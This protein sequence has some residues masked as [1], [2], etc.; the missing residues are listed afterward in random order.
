MDWK[1]EYDDCYR[2]TE[3]YNSEDEK[4]N[5]YKMLKDI[6]KYRAS[7]PDAT[8]ASLAMKVDRKILFQEVL[9]VDEDE[10]NI[11]TDVNKKLKLDT[12]K[13]AHLI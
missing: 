1:T 5:C 13:D 11:F 10:S 8:E 6:D 3:L 7:Y 12:A 2:I 4:R 9:G